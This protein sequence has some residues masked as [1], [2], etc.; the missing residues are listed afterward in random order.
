ME[1]IIYSKTSVSIEWLIDAVRTRSQD[2]QDIVVELDWTMKGTR[3]KEDAT[4]LTATRSGTVTLDYNP[5]KFTEFS[6]LTQAQLINW[7]NVHLGLDAIN[8]IRKEVI[9]DI[10]RQTL[11]NQTVPA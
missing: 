5:A 4:P 2:N 7:V 8:I 9:A 1:N 10:T 3:L 6:Q 11:T